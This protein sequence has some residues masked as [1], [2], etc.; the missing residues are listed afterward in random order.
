M[1]ESLPRRMTVHAIEAAFLTRGYKVARETFDLV[2]FRP[3]YNGKRFHARLET[4]GQETVPKGAELDL[5]VDFMR[6]LKGYHGSEAESE[7][8]AREMADVL[9]ALGA[10]DATRSRPRVRC[11]ECGKEL[12]Q[13]AFRAHRRVVHGR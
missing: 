2:A 5:H 6:E 9:G 7:E 8:I 10:Q 1:K 4:H 11:P 12:G 13:E 3:L